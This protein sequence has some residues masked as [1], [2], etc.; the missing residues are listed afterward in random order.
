MSYDTIKVEYANRIATVT[1]NRP[2]KLNPLGRKT[3]EELLTFCGDIERGTEARVVV[4]TGAGSA[5]C[6]GLDADDMRHPVKLDIGEHERLTR[7]YDLLILR[8][9]GIELPT[10]GSRVR[11][12]R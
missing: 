6:V 11:I 9:K 12:R 3:V 8:L 7:M 10:I 1:L 5:F 2:E 4:L